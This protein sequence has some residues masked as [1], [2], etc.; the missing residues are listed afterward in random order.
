MIAVLIAVTSEITAPL[1]L[2]GFLAIVFLPIAD[3]LANRGLSRSIASLFVLVGLAL[4]GVV[5]GW[6]TGGL[7]WTKPRTS[8]RT[9]TRRSRTSMDGWN[10][11]GQRGAG[12]PDPAYDR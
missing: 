3:L 6:G 2:G 12:Q 8:P 10:A 5:V 1:V 11:P 7:W 9:S 4:L